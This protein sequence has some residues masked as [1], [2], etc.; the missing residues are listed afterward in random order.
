MPLTQRD[1]QVQTLS[2]CC[3]QEAFTYRTLRYPAGVSFK[4]IATVRERF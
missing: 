4:R 3:A 1:K 2:P